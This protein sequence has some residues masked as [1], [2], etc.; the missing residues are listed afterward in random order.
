MGLPK[1]GRGAELTPYSHPLLPMGG[2]A[3]DSDEQRWP[4]PEVPASRA[5]D[6]TVP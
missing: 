2:G 5:P 3:G 1:D 6:R 4:S